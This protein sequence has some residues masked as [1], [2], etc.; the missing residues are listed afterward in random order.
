MI[1]YTLVWT[2]NF[3]AEPF[4]LETF[5]DHD[6]MAARLFEINEAKYEDVNW[7]LYNSMVD[8]DEDIIQ[9]DLKKILSYHTEVS[10][11]EIHINPK[12][13]G[14]RDYQEENIKLARLGKILLKYID[15]LSDPVEESE[16]TDGYTD[17]TIDI[18]K[19]LLDDFEE[20]MKLQYGDDW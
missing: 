16:I 15:R 5:K 20:E 4:R 1:M 19:E 14:G 6:T 7:R 8:D 12:W 13:Y 17:T 9:E 11:M 18:V 10:A 3:Y 2:P